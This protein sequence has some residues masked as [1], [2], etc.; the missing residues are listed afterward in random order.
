MYFPRGEADLPLGR[1]A[2]LRDG[3]LEVADT[4]PPYDRHALWAA[5]PPRLPRALLALS[6]L[7]R[8]G[9]AVRVPRRP[10]AST[11]QGSRRTPETIPASGD[12]DR[13]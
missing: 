10:A 5:A 9:N 8:E 3:E 2:D 1:P 12:R 13:S 11:S 4:V 6:R 7:C